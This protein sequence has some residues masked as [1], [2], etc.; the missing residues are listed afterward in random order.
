MRGQFYD[1][2]VHIY[3]VLGPTYIKIDK[4]KEERSCQPS[5]AGLC[6]WVLIHRRMRATVFI[7][8]SRP[9]VSRVDWSFFRVYDIATRDEIFPGELERNKNW[10]GG[11]ELLTK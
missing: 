6:I 7:F 8:Q 10:R 1:S 2:Q 11:G 9:L 5:V 3:I 4:K